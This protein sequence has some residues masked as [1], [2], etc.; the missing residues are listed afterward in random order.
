M[1]E[2]FLKLKNNPWI[3]WPFITAAVFIIIFLLAMSA[4][5]FINRGYQ[6][7]ILSKVTL[8]NN[9][10]GNLDYEQARQLLQQRIDFISRRG[11]VYSHPLKNII[12]YPTVAAIESADTSYSLAAW[13]VDS[14]LEQIF[15]WQSDTSMSQLVS[16]LRAL[17]WGKN[18]D[19]IYQWDQE[20]H[21][22]ILTD[23][24]AEIL[25]GKQEAT[26]TIKDGEL[27]IIP[28]QAG[29]AFDYEQAM[30]DT[31]EQ[32]QN[33]QNQDID[34]LISSEEPQFIA[35]DIEMMR[36]EIVNTAQR[37]HFYFTFD[38]QDWSAPAEIWNTWLT[39]KIG[40]AEPYLG[41]E[42]EIVEEYFKTSGIVEAIEMPVQDA[43]FDII[44]GR[45]TEFISS[46][47]GR[48]LDWEQILLALETVLNNPGELEVELTVQ[49]VE[50]RASNSDVND[51][52]IV[53][54]IGI[55]ESDFSGSPYN[56]VH[57]IGVGAAALN[58]VLIAPE[59]EF[60]L[61]AALG[62]IDGENG[63][64]QELVI[65]GGE[66]IP[67]YGGGLCQI[68]T[69]VFRGAIASGLPIT[70]RRNHS[71]RV[72][73]YEPAGTDATIYSPWPDFKFVN[74]TGKHVLIQTR[75]IGRKLYFDYWGSK[76]GR[77]VSMT[78]P[79]IYNIVPPPE[80]KT[81]KTLDLPVGEEKCTERA[82]NGADAKFDYSVWYSE[83]DEPVN[84]TF[85]S[86]YVP[87]REVCLLGVT[88]EEFA[89]EQASS[90]PEE[91][92]E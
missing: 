72:S 61:L 73:Y 53:E 63:Y 91:L 59:E 85:H 10:L 46:Q 27:E 92:P 19:L 35:A 23:G 11:F 34:L 13:D 29:Q 50:P 28:E 84:I 83:E 16:K 24:L 26:F 69:T 56:R 49:T 6:D 21:L 33:L 18:F 14:S 22:E 20:Q 41:L 52:G 39:I 2:W 90:T 36:E 76:D 45:V 74:D 51:L 37:G 71:Y 3:K 78:E 54:I 9:E 55:G 43:K 4:N 25:P 70:Q 60:S 86:H 57:N 44:D 64:L 30:A 12:V 81:I 1:F 80:K 17:W 87:W 38:Q 89:A 15:D 7:K 47:I 40:P 62:D 88:E 65:K 66:T 79:V 82:H 32:I 8:G 77:Q 75:I 67:E 68:G 58:G 42:L 31:L 5:V 48:A